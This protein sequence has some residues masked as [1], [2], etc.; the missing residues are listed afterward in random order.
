MGG[1]LSSSFTQIWLKAFN[2]RNNY[3]LPLLRLNDFIVN[4]CAHNDKTTLCLNP[5]SSNSSNKIE[6]KP[7][8][9]IIS[10]EK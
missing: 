4:D 1:T 2:A 9:P 6:Q 8:T 10:L 7:V 5:F 3:P